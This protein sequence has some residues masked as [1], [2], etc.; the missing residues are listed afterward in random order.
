MC[1]DKQRAFLRRMYCGH[2]IHHKCLRR[3]IERGKF[4]CKLDGEKFLHGFESL[5]K[6]QK[7]NK[8][9]EQAPAIK[10]DEQKDELEEEQEEDNKKKLKTEKSSSLD[11]RDTAQ[12]R[13]RKLSASNKK[14]LSNADLLNRSFNPE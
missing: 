14:K 7:L 8:L 5:I 11:E 6:H 4:F 9:I 10:L 3:R 2:F 13:N 12:K 1:D